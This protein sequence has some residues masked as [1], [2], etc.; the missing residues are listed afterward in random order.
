MRRIGAGICTGPY[1]APRLGVQGTL[2]G[3][4]GCFRFHW[5]PRKLI[6]FEGL[7]SGS[8]PV[9]HELGDLL[10]GSPDEF[11]RE[12][13]QDLFVAARDVWLSPEG[14][15]RAEILALDREGRV[16]LVIVQR[17]SD[18][19]PLVH[20]IVCAGAVASWLEV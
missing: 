3:T 11:L 19:S 16:V 18:T 10:A 8:L 13:G 6:S 7:P 12:I 17:R 1:N 9:D 4:C 20:T 5:G 14:A 15:V 2:G